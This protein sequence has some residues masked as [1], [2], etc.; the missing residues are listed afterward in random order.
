MKKNPQLNGRKK[1][2]SAFTLIELLVVIAIIAILAALLLPVLSR[3]KAKAKAIYCMNNQKQIMLAETLYM[4]DNKSSI[5]PLWIE[6]GA[7]NWPNVAYDPAVFSIQVPF[8]FWWPDNLRTGGEGVTTEMVDCP[9]LTQPGTLNDG[10]SVNTNL[11]LGIGM[12]Y[13]EYGWIEPI[14]GGP[15]DPANGL[16][17]ENSVGQPSQSIVYADAAGISNPSEPD[18]D[19]WKE[20]PGSGCV[21]FRAPTDDTSPGYV[22]GDARSVPRHSKRVNVTFFDG[23]V[24][25]IKNSSIGYQDPR[26]NDA[27]LWARNHIGLVP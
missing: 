15:V 7:P 24:E 4:D 2:A 1:W 3:A 27:A 5:V 6:Q 10:G 23:H 12:N 17:N 8:L 13:P 26:T 16:P 19:N 22:S 18:A 9:A 20:V 25:A 14:S 11:P 21:Y